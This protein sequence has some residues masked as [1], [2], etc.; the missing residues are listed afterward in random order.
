MPLVAYDPEMLKRHR[1][2]FAEEASIIVPAVVV[3]MGKDK[4]GAL[5][6]LRAWGFVTGKRGRYEFDVPGSKRVPVI[7]SAHPS[8]TASL[9]K[10]AKMQ[11]QFREACAKARDL[12]SEYDT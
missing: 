12:C 3:V 6:V 8:S 1:G 11:E 7:E 2:Y 5:G 10:R 9:S 4:L